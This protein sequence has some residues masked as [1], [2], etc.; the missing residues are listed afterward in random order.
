MEAHCP[1]D[2]DRYEMWEAI[3]AEHGGIW[4]SGGVCFECSGTVYLNLGSLASADGM[5]G[6]VEVVSGEYKTASQRVLS[7]KPPDLLMLQARPRAEK[8]CAVNSPTSSFAI[9]P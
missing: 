9:Q 5:E 8:C 7:E 3:G 2:I 4:L 6:L 1:A